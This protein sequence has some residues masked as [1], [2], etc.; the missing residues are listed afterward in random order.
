MARKLQHLSEI[1]LALTKDQKLAWDENFKSAGVVLDHLIA[2]MHKHVEKERKEMTLDK[3][4][5]STQPLNVLLARQAKIEAF[6]E[7]ID[8]VIDK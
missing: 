2:W 4:C 1:T 6:Q 5:E 3:L 8:L 7:I